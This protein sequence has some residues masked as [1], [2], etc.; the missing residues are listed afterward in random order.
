MKIKEPG[1][2][3]GVPIELYHGDL[4]EGPSI[5]SS[6]LRKIANESPA[7]YFVDSYLNPDPPEEKKTPEHFI[8]GRAAHHLL[9]GE[10]DFSTQFIVRPE[11]YAEKP[12]NSNRTD[13]KE[14]LAKQAKGGRTVL[15]PAQIKA[16]RGM[17]KSLAETP[18]VKSGIL[19]GAVEQTG[20]WVDKETGIYVKIR[21]D[22]IPNDSGDVCDLKTTTDV[23]YDELSKTIGNFG[24]HQQGALVGE[25]MQALLGRPMTSFSLC[26]VEKDAPWC[27]RIVTLKDCDLDRGRKQNRV[28]LRIFADC[29]DKGEWPGP[30]DYSEAEFIEIP[31]WLQTRIDHKLEMLG[32]K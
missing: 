8:L 13:C 7:H 16:I 12:W 32:I 28:A 25:G 29:I 23:G 11:A 19:N 27:A 30:G 21:P 5:S 6:G 17:A 20:V 10:D 4:C 2:Y 18:L 15:L 22:C 3:S 31:S 26:F 1:I 14:W 24:Y 9:L